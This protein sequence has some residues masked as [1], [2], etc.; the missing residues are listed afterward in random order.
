MNNRYDPIYNNPKKTERVET[1]KRN[2]IQKYPTQEHYSLHDFD[3]DGIIDWNDP[4][5]DT[6]RPFVDMNGNHIVDPQDWQIQE[7]LIRG[8]LS[9]G[10]IQARGII[11]TEK[12]TCQVL[13]FG[14]NP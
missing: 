5:P 12:N 8:F 4:W 7:L 14:E 6:H 13:G 10:L 11:F 2:E 9:M 1:S 3:N